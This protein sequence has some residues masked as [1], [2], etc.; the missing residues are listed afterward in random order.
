MTQLTSGA[1]K[2]INA[3]QKPKGNDYPVVQVLAFKKIQTK[4]KQNNQD[5]YRVVL[6]DGEH[7][8]QAMLGIQQNELI[9]SGALV[10]NCIVQLK[11]YLCNQVQG[12]K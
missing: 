12:K 4:T 7:F 3:N 6:S 11:E 8:L 5:R 1:I 10:T 9:H 2:A